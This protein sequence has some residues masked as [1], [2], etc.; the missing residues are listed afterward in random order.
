MRYRNWITTKSQTAGTTARIVRV[1][2]FLMLL[3]V[4]WPGLPAETNHGTLSAEEILG[5]MEE[6][7][8]QQLAVLDSYRNLRRYSI[9]HPLLGDGTYW[10]VEEKFSTPDEKRFEV[11]ERGGSGIVQKRVFARLLEVEQETTREAVRPQVD[12]LRDN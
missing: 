5:R 6:R 7:F 12:L 4:A 9:D 11:L 3:G 8:L 10:V 1:L 2:G